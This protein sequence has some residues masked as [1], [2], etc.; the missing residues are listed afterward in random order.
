MSWVE[1]EMDLANREWL[2]SFQIKLFS[3][4]RF[5][6]MHTRASRK[7]AEA[8]LRVLIVEH[9]D[10]LYQYAV[11]LLLFWTFFYTLI[12][13]FYYKFIY[14][15]SR[16]R[17]GIYRTPPI[18]GVY[19][20][21]SVSNFTWQNRPLSTLLELNDQ[22][23]DLEGQIQSLRDSLSWILFMSCSL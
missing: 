1:R 6:S 18:N 9:W 20:T 15:L 17:N 22:R 19:S 10:V 3:D 14:F 2:G 16:L 23:N 7:A 13:T 11:F 21:L 8:R 4:Q 12:P 5:R